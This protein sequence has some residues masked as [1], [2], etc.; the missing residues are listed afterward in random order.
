MSPRTGPT[1]PGPDGEPEAETE[2]PPKKGARPR[3]GT[4]SPT[5]KPSSPASLQAQLA[6]LITGLGGAVAFA[7]PVDGQIIADQADALASALDRLAKQNPMVRRVLQSLLIGG[8][9][10]EV[11]SVV[12]LGVVLP[13]A[14][15]HGALPWQKKETPLPTG[16]ADLFAGL[17]SKGTDSEPRA[18]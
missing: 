16:V 11:L 15:N 17:R 14:M 8:A 3:P 2:A 4:A 5:R 1:F 7:N 6:E 13:I 9:W 10:G 12:V 18:E